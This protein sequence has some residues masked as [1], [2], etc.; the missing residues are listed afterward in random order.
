MTPRVASGIDPEQTGVDEVTEMEKDASRLWFTSLVSG[1][2]VCLDKIVMVIAL[3]V[4]RIGWG[5][6]STCSKFSLE[7]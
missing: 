6:Q 1:A 3:I 7:C 5:L 2:T 4:Y